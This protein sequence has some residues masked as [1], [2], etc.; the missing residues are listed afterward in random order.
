MSG[1]PGPQ[2][3]NYLLHTIKW[4]S[5]IIVL[6]EAI[7]IIQ[8]GFGVTIAPPPFE[9]DLLQL[10]GVTFA[11]V[12]EEIGFRIILIGIPLF[13]LYSHRAS[14]KLFFKSLWNPS[15]NLPITDSKKAVILVIVV[16]VFFGKIGRAHV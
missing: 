16:A 14:A 6:S 3:G 4:L 7:D 12:I 10:L 9:N 1:S 8:Q 5:V 15:A 2:D 11:P 13:L